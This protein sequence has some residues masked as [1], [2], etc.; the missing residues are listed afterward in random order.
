ML[1]TGVSESKRRPIKAALLLL[2]LVLVAA[3]LI[4]PVSYVVVL[5]RDSGEKYFARYVEEGDPVR[6]SWVHSVEHTPWVEIYQVYDGQLALK[7]S[8]IKSFGAGV[9]QVAPEV[10]NKN[11]WVILR[12]TG[13]MFHALH[14]IY[15]REAAYDLQIDGRK[16][17]LQERVP[18]HA[19]IRVGVKQTSRVLWWAEQNRRER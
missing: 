7:E 6:L 4:E 10:A 3:W 1:P 11:G 15:S 9:D 14:L 16:L 8:R 19:A 12:G 18:H 2:S 13:R 5:D 17:G